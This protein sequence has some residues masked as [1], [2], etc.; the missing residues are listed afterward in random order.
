MQLMESYVES[1]GSIN[2]VRGFSL[3][4][5]VR[6]VSFLLVTAR[7]CFCRKCSAVVLLVYATVQDH[8]ENTLHAPVRIESSL[9]QQ[10]I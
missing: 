3:M 6:L 7:Q 10:V 2:G 1:F 5:L 4:R 9:I 8:K